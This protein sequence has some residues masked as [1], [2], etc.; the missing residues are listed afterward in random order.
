MACLRAE[1]MVME[2]NEH[3]VKQSFRNRCHLY[4]ANGLLPLIIPVRHEALFTKPITEVETISDEPWKKIHW[5]SIT[6]AYRNSPFFEYY[7]D[8]FKKLFHTDEIFLFNFNMNCMELIFKILQH[9]PKIYFA[10]HYEK[11]PLTRN[12]LR[13]VYHPKN[14]ST[15]KL[16]R[17]HQVFE[18]RHGFL[19]D[20]SILD[21]LCNLGPAGIGYLRLTGNTF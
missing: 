18:E 17:Y 16:P 5:R 12:D 21:L 3:F 19:P 4:G 1:E 11:S 8:D 20:L 9:S 10:E 14:I 13:H 7:E 15:E 6:S 2:V